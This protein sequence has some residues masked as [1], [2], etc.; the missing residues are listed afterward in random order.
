VRC[1]VEACAVNSVER[2][3]ARRGDPCANDRW[4]VSGAWRPMWDVSRNRGPVWRGAVI[5]GSRVHDR[6]RRI[7]QK[8]VPGRR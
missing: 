8:C 1:P 5:R 2:R 3:A 4:R 6:R 7:C